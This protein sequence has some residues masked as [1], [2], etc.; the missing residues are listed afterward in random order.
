MLKVKKIKKYKKGW[1]TVY[2]FPVCTTTYKKYNKHSQKEGECFLF[3]YKEYINP[4]KA[5]VWKVAN[6]KMYDIM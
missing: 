6:N 3:L 5:V 4:I 1:Y 2:M